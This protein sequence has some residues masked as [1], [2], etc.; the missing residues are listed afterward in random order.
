[1]TAFLWTEEERKER[2]WKCTESSVQA[3][4]LPGGR[5]SQT[6]LVFI[7]QEERNTIIDSEGSQ[8]CL[9]ISL[10]SGNG[11]I[12]VLIAVLNLRKFVNLLSL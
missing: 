10:I 2:D 3:V 6:V 1:M 12:E 11:Y 9:M 8:H 7:L 4:R 5:R